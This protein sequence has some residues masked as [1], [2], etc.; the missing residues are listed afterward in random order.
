[1][2]EVSNDTI[3]ER[4]E[5]LKDLVDEKFNENSRNHKSILDQVIYTNGKVRGLLV[6]RA[7]LTG[8]LAVFSIV[9]SILGYPLMKDYISRQNTE[10]DLDKK[11]SEA[12][13]RTLSNYEAQL[14][15]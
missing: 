13:E 14:T 8:G 9:F 2:S 10:K 6:W 1:M 12:V 5:G 11:I 3:V 4:I 15:N 7:Y